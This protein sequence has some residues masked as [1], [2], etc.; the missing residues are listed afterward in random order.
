M[1]RKEQPQ[2]PFVGYTRVSRQGSRSDEELLSHDLQRKKIEGYCT[3]R[4][5]PLS[6]E[7]LEDTD[8][9][10][11]KMDRPDFNKALLGIKEGRYGGIVVAKLSRF[12]RT[13]LGALRTIKEIE[14]V[15]GAF[16]CIDPPVD[17]SNATGRA[18]LKVFLAF[19]ELDIE[20]GRETTDEVFDQKIL[21]DGIHVAAA[22]PAGYS[23]KILN[24]Q[25]RKGDPGQADPE[26]T[27][28]SCP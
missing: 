24:D 8:E 10:G 18:M 12:C 15:G 4:D 11:G 23:Y 27:R 13:T 22:A 5:L 2:K 19:L 26:W 9:S 28:S 7:R 14:R 25:E 6:R 20:Q 16:V 21:E 3:A 1:S 17:T